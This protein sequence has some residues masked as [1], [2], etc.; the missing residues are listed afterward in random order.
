[1]LVFLVVHSGLMELAFLA[2]NDA[3]HSQPELKLLHRQH[4]ELHVVFLIQDGGS[5]HAAASTRS[6]FAERGGWWKPQYTPANASWL[7]QAEILIHAFKPIY[8]K[9]ASWKN[10]EEFTTPM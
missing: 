2:S 6:Y 7:K 8:L 10:Q 5:S 4:K 1:M 3:E 9:R